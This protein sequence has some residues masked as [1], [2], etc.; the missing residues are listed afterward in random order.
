MATQDVILATQDL[1]SCHASDTGAVNLA[2]ISQVEVGWMLLYVITTSICFLM[3]YSHYYML[4]FQDAKITRKIGFLLNINCVTV[5][6]AC[7]LT[8]IG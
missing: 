6:I 8:N 2:T 5:S 3:S 4:A 1:S 7:Q